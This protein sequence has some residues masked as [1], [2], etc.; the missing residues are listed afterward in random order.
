MEHL[1]QA[2]RGLQQ[3]QQRQ[4]MVIIQ[5]RRLNTHLFLHGVAAAATR[6]SISIRHYYT[7][8]AMIHHS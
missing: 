6:S 2:I 7:M 5:Q 3:Q 1:Q 8:I 4:S